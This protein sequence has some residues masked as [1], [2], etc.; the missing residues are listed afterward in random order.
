MNEPARRLSVI[1]L[2][3]FLALMG[4]ASWIQVLD[5]E[6]LNQDPRNVRTLYREYGNFRGPIVVDGEAVVWSDPVDDPFNFQRTYAD[7]PLYA[8]ATGFYSIVYG[9]SGLEQS[10][11]ELLSG[12]ADALFWTR[13]GNLFAGEQQQGAS[14]ETTLNGTLQRVAA[15]QLGD[16]PGAVVALEPS[17]GEILAM[18]TSPTYDP[19]VLASHS[20]AE[21]NSAYE[22]LVN[23]EDGPLVN[24][25][26]AG[27]T[28]PPGS[29]F[30]L[31]VSAAALESGY[32]PETELYAPEELELPGTS[33]TIGNYLGEVCSPDDYM[34]LQD[35]LRI[36]CNTAFADLGM[37]LGWGVLERKA[38]DFGWGE[39]LDIPLPVTASR[40]PEDPNES[41]VAMS[42]IGQ[43]NVRATPL[44]MAMVAA[45]IGNDG[46]LMR[47][48][49]VD[50]VRAP[51][52]QVVS[53]T[54]PE[55]MRESMTRADSDDLTDMMVEVVNNGS[56][57][58]AQIAGVEVAGK[59]GTAETG[60]DTPPHA[61]F[62]SFAPADDP[63]IAIA[64]IIEESAGQSGSTGGTIAA[65]V[66]KAVMEEALRLDAEGDL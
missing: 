43:Y 46:T 36:S 65:P 17:T 9:R 62:V 49:L 28:Y 21:V 15:D 58:G 31:V 22:E 66:A 48:Y 42:S 12:T 19:A 32:T 34:S 45:A 60:R 50:T 54:E 35:A 47:P 56:G 39:E 1:V 6:E 59:T 57:R 23:Q 3:L 44:Q 30:K 26:I 13:L 10:E 4:S 51:D 52:L 53:T 2:L 5:A 27:D 63:A 20:T 33:A 16:R 25:A 38:T 18:V 8:S 24:R 40:L 7:G 29:T 55:V 37:S 61:W 14:V 41:Q 64:V 11:N